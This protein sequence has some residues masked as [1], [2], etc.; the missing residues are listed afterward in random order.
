M[1][2]HLSAAIAMSFLAA[3]CGEPPA[4]QQVQEVEAKPVAAAPAPALVRMPVARPAEVLKHD[5]NQAL[6]ERVK[7]ALEGEAKVHAAAIDVTAAA[8]VVTLWGTA[9]SDDE[10]IRAGRVAYR[11]QGVNTVN[12]RLAIVKGS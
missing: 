1:N 4:R 10:R 6:A 11:V 8:G 5:P 3:S 2:R 12:N 7:Q 9:D